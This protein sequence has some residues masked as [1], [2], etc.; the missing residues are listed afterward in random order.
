[1]KLNTWQKNVLSAVVIVAGGFFLFNVAFLLAAAV[2]NGLGL[3][4]GNVDQPPT[5]IQIGAYIG[6]L[7][8][9]SWLVF[10][11][12]L[13]H[14]VKATYMTMPLMVTLV[15]TGI[16]LYTQPQWMPIGF[17]VLIVA[18][19]LLFIYKKKLPWLY[20]FATFYTAALALY[21]I[22]SGIDI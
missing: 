13:S 19:V 18:A 6:F 22:L 1:M 12:K 8:I 2:I 11:S 17:G 3:L 7:L 4:M 15:M 5:Y 9:I 20:Y 14:L 16:F 21:I 10:R